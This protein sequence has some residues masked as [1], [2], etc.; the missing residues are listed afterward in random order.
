MTFG[1]G[2]FLAGGVAAGAAVSWITA[3]R[4]RV[5]RH[6]MMDV[7]FWGMVAGMIGARLLFVL[8]DLDFF[9]SLCSNPDSVL[10]AG[11]G[12]TEGRSCYPGQECV[13]GWCQNFG[14]CFAAAKFWHGGLVFFGG[15]LVGIP[16]V[17][18][19]AKLKR[20]PPSSVLA[21]VTVGVPLG[22]VFGRLGC[23]VK[24]CCYGHPSSHLLA[25]E[26][27]L[28]VQL[29]EAAGE[30]VIFVI[31]FLWFWR[32]T[33]HRTALP[34]RLVLS[35][36]VLFLTLYSPLR[37]TTELLRGDALRGFFVEVS[38]PALAEMF[39]FSP[40]AP[41]LLSTSQGIVLVLFLLA[42]M[43]WLLVWPRA[44]KSSR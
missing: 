41:V 16:A 11:L 4:L 21:L 20:M 25:V 37:F 35:V 14:D 8:L 38:W 28:P 10:P 23:F 15:V 24:G 19:V 29:I 22:H 6:A 32:L 18:L 30:L 36:P 17:V 31:V 39:S 40:R 5:D 26:G 42:L 33:R 34:G 1:Y 27:K 12:C 7:V 44:R 9:V 2:F 3:P 43:Y 13:D